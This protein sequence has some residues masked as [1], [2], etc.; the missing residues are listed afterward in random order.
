MSRRKVLKDVEFRVEYEDGTVTDFCVPESELN[1]SGE[2]DLDVLVYFAK[3]AAN[4]KSP[5]KPNWI[6]LWRTGMKYDSKT[7]QRV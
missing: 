7:G 1:H 4:M 2:D 6:R 3:K 5:P